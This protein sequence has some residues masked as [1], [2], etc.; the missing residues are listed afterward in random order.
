MQAV[1]CIRLGEDL[2]AV[3]GE[4]LNAGCCT[5]D[6]L[7]HLIHLTRDMG[8][9]A[10]GHQPRGYQPLGQDGGTAR[11]GSA[12]G[13]GWGH[14]KGRISHT[15]PWHQCEAWHCIE[16]QSRCHGVAW[17][18]T[19]ART[20]PQSRSPDTATLSLATYSPGILWHPVAPWH[21]P[22]TPGMPFISPL[23]FCPA[24]L[25]N[26]SPAASAD[27]EGHQGEPSG[28]EPAGRAWQGRPWQL[29]S[30]SFP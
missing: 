22:C 5:P 1:V 29:F 23:E 20:G 9:S 11:G 7:F 13:A 15:T 18:C 28:R 3:W 25:S 27:A 12:I 26:P 4:D 8:A 10:M 14:S 6:L 21:P 24:I 16:A 17:H 30:S 2:N 19:E